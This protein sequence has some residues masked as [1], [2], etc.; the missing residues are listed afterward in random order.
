LQYK[1]LEFAKELTSNL[2]DDALLLISNK[3]KGNAVFYS[4]LEHRVFP[5]MEAA[6]ENG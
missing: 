4:H 5:P 2:A 1:I 3:Q 6:C